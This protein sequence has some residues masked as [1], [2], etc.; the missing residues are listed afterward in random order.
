MNAKSLNSSTDGAGMPAPK[1]NNYSM[2]N[3][4]MIGDVFGTELVIEKCIKVME[5][6][7]GEEKGWAVDTVL[8]KDL[9]K[10]LSHSKMKNEMD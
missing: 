6:E 10:G 8:N 2:D 1:L 7:Q 5:R 4:K 3:D 9:V